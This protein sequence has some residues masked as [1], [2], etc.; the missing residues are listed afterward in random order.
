[1]PHPPPFVRNEKKKL[2]NSF[3][4]SFRFFSE[5]ISLPSGG[6]C[7]QPIGKDVIN[8][9]DAMIKNGKNVMCL[10][11]LFIFMFIFIFGINTAIA[12][13]IFKVS[14]VRKGLNKAT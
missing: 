2:S 13:R 9:V 1:M 6:G 5:K 7:T 4:L 8:I 14:S 10:I 3:S 12:A 11:A